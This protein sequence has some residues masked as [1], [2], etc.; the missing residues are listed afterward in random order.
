MNRHFVFPLL[1]FLIFCSCKS[2][3]SS[4]VVEK[5]NFIIDLQPFDGIT[6]DVT[7]YVFTE[8][9]KIYSFVEIKRSI[10]LPHAAYYKARNRYRADSLINFLSNQAAAGHKIIGLTSLDISTTKNGIADWGVMGL[11]FCPGKACIAST[12]RLSKNDIKR[13]LFKVAIHEMGHTFGLPHCEMKY[14]FM[15]DAEGGNPTN[16]EKEFC[17]KCK[18][19]LI[20][21]G[22]NLN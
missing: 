3:D 5:T 12:F 16:E 22:W 8:L 1:I 20:S 6:V 15:R 13:Q 4:R 19:F 2:R 10:P 11:G 18:S 14:C 7:Q 9:K 21:K 17:V